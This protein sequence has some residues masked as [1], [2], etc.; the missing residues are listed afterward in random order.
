MDLGG[1]GSRALFYSA[2]DGQT[3]KSEGSGANPYRLGAEVAENVISLHLSSLG[4]ANRCIDLVLIGMAGVSSPVSRTVVDNAFKKAGLTG[5]IKLISDAELT[6]MAAFAGKECTFADNTINIL[7]IAGTGSI[8]VTLSQ[9]DGHLIRAGGLGHDNG[10][11]G[12]GNWIGNKIKGLAQVNAELAGSRALQACVA[13]AGV[14]SWTDLPAAALTVS[15]DELASSYQVALDLS[16]QAGYELAKIVHSVYDQQLQ[17][18]HQNSGVDRS[19]AVRG[20]VKCYGSVI[21]QCKT[22]RNAFTEALQ[23]HLVDAGDVT[24]VLSELLPK[25]IRA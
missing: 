6:H 2:N 25:L 20:V 3:L 5:D 7:L 10:D 9:V 23:T 14:I 16:S 15:L 24:D 21:K 8:A 12:S 22:V 13:A 18:L 1:T 17:K 19:V 11:E 4:L